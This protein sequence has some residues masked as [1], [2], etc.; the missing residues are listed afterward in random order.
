MGT[1]FPSL[2]GDTRW[3]IRAN[4]SFPVPLSP[5]MSTVE[6]V[7]AIFMANLSTF[8]MAGDPAMRSERKRC[9]ASA[10]SLARPA[11]CASLSS[12]AL[13]SVSFNGFTR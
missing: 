9:S 10:S 5:P 13:R 4:S 7:G 1:N 8:S 2:R 3:M 12:T 11:R 6:A